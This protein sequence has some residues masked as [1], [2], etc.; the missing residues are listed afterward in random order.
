[1]Y[2]HP[3]YA[4]IGDGEEALKEKGID[5]TVGKAFYKPNGRAKAMNEGDGMVK[6]LADKKTDRLLGVYL[7]GAHAS[8]LIS[9]MAIAFEFGASAEDIARSVHAHPTLA[10]ILK[11]AAQAA[12]G[13]AIHA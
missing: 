3:E 10:E 13:W 12:C 5:Y 6:I 9:E 7:V 1:M 11:D 8:N 2:T 4:F